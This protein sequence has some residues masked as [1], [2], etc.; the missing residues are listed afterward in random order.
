MLPRLT[1]N[2]VL[3]DKRGRATGEFFRW[4][5]EGELTVFSDIA[6]QLG[7]ATSLTT[8]TAVNASSLTLPPGDWDVTMMMAFTFAATT[9]VTRLSA[10]IS[11]TIN[12]LDDTTTGASSKTQMAALVPGAGVRF[13]LNVGPRR[14]TVGDSR[15]VHG[16]AF[17]T[18]TVDTIDASCSI[19]AKRTA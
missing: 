7:P 8:N 9:S 6:A 4:L 13:I 19:R 11:L 16:V 10:S 2:T 3:V 5:A 17:A 14:V 15:I 18:F 1:P 12:T